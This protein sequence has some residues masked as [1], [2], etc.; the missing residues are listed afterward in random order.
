MNVLVVVL[1]S[2]RH[3]KVGCYGPSVVQTPHLDALSAQGVLLERCYA[4][5]PNTI[6]SRT[7]L[8]A[9]TYTFT[10]RPWKELEDRDLHIAE[11]FQAAGYRTAAFSDTPFN[12]G[13]RM[14]RGF[15]EFRHFPMG[16]CL[17]P[18][19]D[20]P[21]LP[22]DDA[23]FP[24]GFPEKEILYYPKTKTNR[25]YCLRKY[26]KYLPEMMIDE[27]EAWL[28]AHR[29]EPF[30]L[31][32]DNFNPHE[33]WDAPEPWRSMY[34]PRFGYDGRYLPMPMGPEMDWVM[35]GDLEHIHAL[36]NA[37]ATETDHYMGRLFSVLDELDL[38]EDT[39]LVVLSD[40]GVPLG[41]HGTIR[42]F[43]YP[44]YE[45]L[46]HTVQI[47][48]WPG[49]LPAGQRVPGLTSNVDFLPTV[50]AAAGIG[51]P[52]ELDGT[53]LL[54][55]MRGQVDRVREHLFLGAFNYNAGVI[56][57]DGWKFIDHRG[58]KPNELYHLPTDPGEQTDL[59]RREPE[60]AEALFRVLYDFHEPW[61]WKRSRHHRS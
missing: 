31:W 1:D 50:L 5:F 24:P 60:R 6:P 15:Q 55:L 27:V 44:L 23:F 58:S 18:I 46:A 22:Y 39:L 12:S 40:H 20:Q 19:D 33:P 3:D 4:E 10:N 8:V 34:E 43:N 41:E 59:A 42:K 35:P 47:W 57:D 61:R 28:R 30:F 11:L 37:C 16:K 56:T 54:P 48:R 45:E 14:D 36:A 32:L 2:L 53:N 38:A 9:G 52:H 13:A 25:A 51:P 17:P 29:Q 49:H 21:L 26:G 7:A